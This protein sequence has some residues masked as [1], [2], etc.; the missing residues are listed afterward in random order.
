MIDIL[1]AYLLDPII[2]R[3]QRRWPNINARRWVGLGLYVLL[4]LLFTAIVGGFHAIMR[5][6]PYP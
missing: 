3:V 4:A 5:E 1:L 6:A 2:D